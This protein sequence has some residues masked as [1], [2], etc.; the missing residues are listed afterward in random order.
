MKLARP[1]FGLRTLLGLVALSA[2]AAWIARGMWHS[3]PPASTLFDPPALLTSK[4]VGQAVL[5]FD[6]KTT[7]RWKV[8]GI[9]AVSDGTFEVG[10]N[11][12]TAV[13]LA[14]ELGMDFELSF[15]FFQEGP[16]AAT[17]RVN[18]ILLDPNDM[19]TRD[20]EVDLHRWNFVYK[21]WHHCIVT[22]SYQSGHF[23]VDADV[24]PIGDGFGGS[25]RANNG[26]PTKGLRCRVGFETAAGS[27]LYLRNIR[28]RG[29]P[30]KS[31][32]ESDESQPRK[33]PAV[34][35]LN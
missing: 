26:F 27:K 7:N 31:L 10:G 32:D 34:T 3:G 29:K 1:Q 12:A 20:I 16:G 8:D 15:D 5:I 2:L 13:Y 33:Q 6:G 9:A 35:R 17:F 23:S 4:E 24:E 18:P 28:F 11:A 21:R 14:D 30:A 22:A 19:H 25:S